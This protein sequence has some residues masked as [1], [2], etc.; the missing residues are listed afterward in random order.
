[1][2]LREQISIEQYIVTKSGSISVETGQ[3]STYSVSEMESGSTQNTLFE[4][5][6]R[7]PKIFEIYMKLL[8]IR[9]WTRMIESG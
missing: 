7:W 5:A 4:A 3:D 9:V 8:K 2:E 6:S 1:M